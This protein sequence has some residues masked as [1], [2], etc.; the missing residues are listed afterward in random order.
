MKKERC[1]PKILK[2]CWRSLLAVSLMLSCLCGTAAAASDNVVPMEDLT[3]EAV[4]GP[5]SVWDNQPDMRVTTRVNMNVAANRLSVSSTKF[6]LEIGETVTFN[7]SY[8]PSSAS[9]DF[10]VIAPNGHFYYLNATN[11]SINK[12][13]R[14]SQRGTYSLAVRNNSASTVSVAGFVSY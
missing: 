1:I 12:T 10:G 8:T 13:I 3:C 4:V 7:C 2:K 14:V 6:S 5:V 11:G 9:V